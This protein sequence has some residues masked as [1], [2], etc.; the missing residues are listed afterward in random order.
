LLCLYG[1]VCVGALWSLDRAFDG[2]WVFSGEGVLP[3][4]WALLQLLL[5]TAFAWPCW[6]ASR[7]PFGGEGG[8]V[9]V[10]AAVGVAA[11]ALIIG[12][13]VLERFV[14]S[15]DEYAYL[16]QARTYLA[17]RLWNPPPV[18]GQA[19]ASVYTW[20]HGDKWVGQYP[21]GWPGL[22][23][24][25][26]LVGI[27]AWAVN[28]GLG[29]GSVLLLW[30]LARQ[31][32]G[33]T[34]VVPAVLAYTA[35][36]FLLFNAG[37]LHSHMAA[38][39]AG[40]LAFSLAEA[41]IERRSWRLAAATGAA[42]GWLA[43]VRYNSAALMALPLLADLL[44]RA[45]GARWR[46]LLAAAVGGLPFVAG[47]LAY[48]WAITG[49]PLTPVYYFSGRTT[50]HLYF[51]A[52]GM[53]DGARISLFRLVELIEWTAPSLVLVWVL[54]VVA[55]LRGRSLAAADA[56]FPLF[57]VF[58]LFYPFDGANRYGPRYWFDAF[59][60]LVLTVATAGPALAAV[61]WTEPAKRLAA[62]AVVAGLAT[63]PFVAERTNTIVRQRQDLADRVAAQG[64]ADA[65]VV[66]TADTGI[67]WKM[68]QEDLARNGIDADGSVLFVRGE[69]ADEATVRAAFPRR[70]VWVYG[71]G[72][73]DGDCRLVPAP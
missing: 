3:L 19:M 41:A 23:A 2:L 9:V 61:G 50:D 20:V 15:A 70:T 46:L 37:S 66:I 48:H 32:G 1:A 14:N 54:A 73:R 38:A 72:A 57:V 49:N 26:E 35:S 58:F 56:V 42:I 11:V 68:E 18:L 31:R 5:A 33:G 12:G 52:Q 36:P 45:R 30:R 44:L 51:D 4:Q 27:P 16:F 67:L 13:L 47:L 71:C 59:P 39:F 8:V 24:A 7:S 40:L 6:R 65:V 69:L 43:T 63:L 64:L 62:L 28:S 55:K 34:M 29:G 10:A 60:F 22:L 25:A 17:G 21:P 53:A